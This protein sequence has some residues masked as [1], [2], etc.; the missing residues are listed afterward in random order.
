[1]KFVILIFF[2]AIFLVVNAQAL[3]NCDKALESI[4]KYK[5]SKNMFK[6]IHQFKA[7]YSKCMD[8]GIAEGMSAVIVSSLDRSWTSVEEVDKLSKK[9]SSFKKFI[10]ANIQPQVTGQESQVKNIIKKAKNYCPK[11]MKKFCRDLVK[12]SQASLKGE[13]L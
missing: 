9:D 10:L 5:S 2:A 4:P 13:N 1:M 11:K 8:G 12:S 7:K 3:E 6:E